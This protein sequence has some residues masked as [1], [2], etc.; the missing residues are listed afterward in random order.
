MVSSPGDLGEHRQELRDAILSW[1]SA[2]GRSRGVRLEPVLWESHVAPCY[3]MGVQ[4]PINFVVDECDFGIAVFWSRMGSPTADAPSGTVE[5]IQRLSKQRKPVLL[6]VCGEPVSLTDVN[7]EQLSALKGWL[8][9]VE[10]MSLR[11]DPYTWAALY[12]RLPNDLTKIVD[13]LEDKWKADPTARIKEAEDPNSLYE[14]AIE[15]FAEAREVFDVTLGRQPSS[16]RRVNRECDA[17][18]RFRSARQEFLNRVDATGY[19]ELI[20]YDA[21][22]GDARARYDRIAEG[23]RAAQIR[24]EDPSTKGRPFQA[25]ALFTGIS[26]S[27]PTIDFFVT[28]K[29]CVLLQIPIRPPAGEYRYRYL[30]IESPTLANAY[31]E[32]FRLLAQSGYD[33][34]VDAEGIMEASPPGLRTFAP[35]PRP[36][37]E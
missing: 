4:K 36:E 32:Y 35:L 13:A 20:G 3:G 37:S 23:T 16:H 1:N 33:L 24:R 22:H 34:R 7:I 29:G 17:A 28:D 26:G 6:Y 15:A 27:V 2:E 19:Y 9:Q 18:E 12:Q 31:R 30:R 5:E 14:W 25:L 10:R 11:C 21:A 8:D